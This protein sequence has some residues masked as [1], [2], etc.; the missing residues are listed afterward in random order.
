[1]CETDSLVVRVVFLFFWLEA[2]FVARKSLLKTQQRVRARES[3]YSKSRD[4]I[5]QA[6]NMRG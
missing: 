5:E 4:H 6:L 2:A 1:M 3:H